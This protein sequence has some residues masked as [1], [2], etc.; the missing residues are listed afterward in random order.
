[1]VGELVVHIHTSTVYG[2]H[3][4]GSGGATSSVSA[5]VPPPCLASSSS[6]SVP[7]EKMAS[8]PASI[9]NVEALGHVAWHGA[10]IS[11]ASLTSCSTKCRYGDIMYKVR[12]MHGVVDIGEKDKGMV[13][14]A[15][16]VF[17]LAYFQHMA[18]KKLLWTAKCLAFQPTF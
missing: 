3:V 14:D 8:S 16:G 17:V 2:E 6:T 4:N 11:M 15:L 13:E 7:P 9:G 12:Y 5:S 18:A 1:M 10:A